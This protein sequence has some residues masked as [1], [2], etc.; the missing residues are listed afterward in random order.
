[1]KYI[2]LILFSNLI[3]NCKSSSKEINKDTTI[4]STTNNTASIDLTQTN[5]QKTNYE[6]IKIEK[7]ALV[8]DSVLTKAD[9]NQEFE[10]NKLINTSILKETKTAPAFNHE[11]WH[12]LLQKHVSN[13]GNVNYK[14]FKQDQAQL[15]AYIQQLASNLPTKQWSKNEI[16]AYWINAYNALTVDLILKNYPLASIKDIK[17]PW[18]Q[19]LWKLGDKWYNLNEIEHDILRKMDEPRIHFAIVC[20]S[21][22]CPKLSNKAYIAEDLDAQLTQFTKEFL[23]D[24]NRNIITP[25]EVN[26]SKIF[27]WF[28]KDFKQNGSLI[29]FINTYT[30]IEV[31]SNAKTKY[32]DYNWALNE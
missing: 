13:A 5:D 8:K 32:L 16:L 19:R 22:S 12:N 26:I 17:N 30:D 28:S 4:T 14:G 21:F 24:K 6:K 18:D 11:I 25:N 3:L 10:I 29:D 23:A 20:A 1:M 9:V 15:K 7:T 2:V 31:A 27:Q